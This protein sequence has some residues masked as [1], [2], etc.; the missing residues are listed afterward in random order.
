[1]ADDYKSEIITSPTKIAYEILKRLDNKKTEDIEYTIFVDEMAEDGY[2]KQRVE[3]VIDR[4]HDGGRI[5]YP[6]KR[7]IKLIK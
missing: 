7:Y 3:D 2:D 1:M 5:Y 4:L 6:V